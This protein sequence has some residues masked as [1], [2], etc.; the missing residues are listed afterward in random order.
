MRLSTG[1]ADMDRVLGGGLQPGSVVALVAPPDAQ[2]LP[3]LCAH[4][5]LRPTIYFTTLRTAASIERQLEQQ[6]RAPNLKGVEHVDL[7]VALETITGGLE[8]LEDGD[9]LV[10]DVVDPIEQ[11]VT[12]P[13]YVRFLNSISDRLSA[14]GGVGM[15]H[16]LESRTDDD[17]INRELT[18][19]IADHVWRLNPRR[20]GTRSLDYYL[21]IP[22]ASGVKL[23]D[24]DRVLELDIGSTVDV[25]RTRDY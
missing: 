3:L 24:E 12:M 23:D 4:V 13:E 7:D 8:D 9:D 11:T 1:I 17:S 22:K 10:V 5:H 20:T 18:L 6:G 19:G 14:V 21:E 25:D 16:C 2:S 15:L